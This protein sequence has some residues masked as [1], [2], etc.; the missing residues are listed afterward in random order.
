MKIRY[1]G[2]DTGLQIA[3]TGQVVNP[4]DTIE[5]SDPLGKSLT[6]QDIWEPVKAATKDKK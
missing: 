4:G 1:V 2:Q 6:Q 3:A 5:V